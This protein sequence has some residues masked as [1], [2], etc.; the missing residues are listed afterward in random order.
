MSAEV[1]T[2]LHIS[3]DKESLF[4]PYTDQKNKEIGEAV[5]EKNKSVRLVLAPEFRDKRFSKYVEKI[6]K[7]I[8]AMQLPDEL[9]DYS[10]NFEAWVEHMIIHRFND[11]LFGIEHEYNAFEK[12]RMEKNPIKVLMKQLKESTVLTDE[13]LEKAGAAVN[14]I[15]KQQIENLSFPDPRTGQ[16]ATRADFHNVVDYETREAVVYFLW[17]KMAARDTEYT[18]VNYT[19]REMTPLELTSI[20]IDILDRVYI[21]FQWS[22]ISCASISS[23]QKIVD[24]WVEKVDDHISDQNAVIDDLVKKL[25]EEQKKD[26]EYVNNP[27]LI[28]K[29]KEQEETIKRLQAELRKKDGELLKAED[30]YRDISEKYKGLKEQ[31][32]GKKEDRKTVNEIDFELDRNGRYVFAMDDWANMKNSILKRFPNASFA[33]ETTFINAETTDLCVVLTSVMSH[34]LYY[35]IRSKCEGANIAHIH[36]NSTNLDIIEKEMAKKLK[37]MQEKKAG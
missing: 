33:N 31:T 25:E 24:I 20:Y 34:H 22:I 9:N 8:L 2:K 1:V 13:R 26:K 3:G 36:C 10:Y 29:I 16:S 32:E 19:T 27:E 5:L 11:E 6:K 12:R 37:K 17:S 21:D 4:S 7:A 18:M 28:S 23:L 14:E 15:L 30:K 35:A